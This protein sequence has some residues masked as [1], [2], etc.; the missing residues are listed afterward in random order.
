MYV[1][2]HFSPQ[3]R[4]D[5]EDLETIEELV[6]HAVLADRA[7]AAAVCLTEHHIAGFNTYCDPF[8]MGAYLAP[9]LEQAYIA[10]HVVQVPFHN[11]VRIAEQSNMLDLLTRG[12]CMIALAPG[13]NRQI[14]L[15]VFGVG[16]DERGDITSERAATLQ[17]IWGWQAGDPPLDVSTSRD[18]G[19]LHGRISPSS[20]RKPH[21]LVGRATMTDATIVETA[22][23]GWPVVLAL[24]GDDEQNRRQA[25]LYRTTLEESGH[26]DATVRECLSWLSLTSLVSI[27]PT[28]QEARR[29]HE[30]YLE[31]GG[32]GPI[33]RS[34]D[35]GSQAW[36]D[37]W[38]TRQLQ[39][40][41]WS[42]VGTPEMIAEHLLAYRDIGV[43]HARVAFVTTPGK[44]EQNLEALQLFIEETLPL[45]D[46]QQLPGPDRTVETDAVHA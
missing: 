33:V 36:V 1:S 12:R 34:A 45:L 25:A 3:S 42:V 9:R 15:D 29:R 46:P 7:G 27:A 5:A 31:I 13:S 2:L 16:L 6:E 24:R 19:T 17:R 39:R 11:P 21:P 22:R 23:L 32:A 18:R 43:D 8:L 40:A 20:F 10:V 41:E 44:P 35:E 4:G 38:R 14:E 37:E 26:S 28:E 30:E